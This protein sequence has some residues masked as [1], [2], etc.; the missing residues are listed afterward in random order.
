MDMTERAAE[1]YYD[2]TRRDVWELLRW[3]ALKA[4]GG[5]RQLLLWLVVLPLAPLPLITARHGWAV[6]PAALAST[7][8]LGMALGTLC[9]W[10]E[11]WRAARRMYRWA[12]EYPEYKMVVTE[13]GTQNH[14]PDG[15]AVAYGW[16]EYTGWAETG[17]LF[18]FVFRNGDL[19]WVPK[20]C[21]LTPED[22]D[23]IRS[24]FDRNLTRLG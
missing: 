9:L 16:D 20:R 19:G 13:L 18:V 15:T 1:L 5:R 3:R 10:L 21:A 6:D 8:G 12:A 23:R 2:T 4:P 11:R 24:F 14:R 22:L 17:G 7:L